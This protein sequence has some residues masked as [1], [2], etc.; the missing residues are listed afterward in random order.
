MSW[1]VR[2]AR[3]GDAAEIAQI[4]VDGWRAAYQGIVSDAAL[5]ALDVGRF[6]EQYRAVITMPDP[7]AVFLAASEQRIAAFCGVCPAR[8]EHRD[9]HPR[10]PTGEIAA[11]YAD[12]PLLGTGAG[13]AAHEEGI[14]HLTAAG[15]EHAVLWVMEENAPARRFYEHHGWACDGVHDRHAV[16]ATQSETVSQVRYSRLLA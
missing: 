14:R 12:P 13:H 8:D 3:L 11:L 5:D 6:A 4:N 1:T 10:R 15:F 9:A 7:V 16:A 2:R